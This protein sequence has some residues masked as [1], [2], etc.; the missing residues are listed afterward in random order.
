MVFGIGTINPYTLIRNWKIPT[1]GD[2]AVAGTVLLTNLP[3]LILSFIYLI[4]NSLLTSMVAAAEWA[5]FAHAPPSSFPRGAQKSAFFLELPY[6]Y[7]I[8]MLVLS[9]LMH[10][11]ISQGFF[12]AQI[13]ERYLW[14]F[15]DN[16]RLDQEVLDKMQVTTTG[17]YSPIAMVLTCVILVILFGSV[18][19]LGTRR[20]RDGMP[21]AGSC[22]L[23][24]SAACHTP[25]ETS[26]LLPVKWGVVRSPEGPVD[27]RHCAFSNDEVELPETGKR[28]A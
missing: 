8:P 12:I 4:L 22:S 9:I 11:L 23:A 15:D 7:S 24:V 5:S 6:Q 20:L 13:F 1:D 3:Q 19:I 2:L 25:G 27:I 26:S 14:D 28:Y 16:D 10:W 18:A 21:L 17:A